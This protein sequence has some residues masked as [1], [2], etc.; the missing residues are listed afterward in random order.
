MRRWWKALRQA[1]AVGIGKTTATEFGWKSA[2]RLPAH[3]A[4]PATRGARRTRRAA[5][6]RARR[7]RRPR[8]S[9]RCMWAP[10]GGGSIRIPGT[11]SGVVGLK[12]TFGRVPQWP[13]GAFGHICCGRAARPLRCV[14]PHSCSPRWRG[15]APRDPFSLPEPKRDFLRGHRGWRAGLAHR[16]AAQPGLRRP[17][18]FGRHAGAGG[19]APRAGRAGGDGARDQP[20][21]TD[22]SEVSP[23]SGA[24]PWPA[25]WICRRRDK[26]A[27]LDAGLLAGGGA[28]PE[29][30][31]AGTGAG[32]GAA[33][34]GGARRWR[35]WRWTQLSAPPC[36]IAPRWPRR[37][38][39]TPWQHSGGTG[40]R[41]PCCSASRA[42]RRFLSPMGVNEAGLPTAVQ[43]SAPVYRDDVVLRVARAVERAVG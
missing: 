18:G 29:R 26:R 10:D 39:T 3:P 36:R 33:R 42:N 22:V 4:S 7:Q 28:G 43:I 30:P 37:R 9:A 32:R 13:L 6:P 1:G 11:W 38:W 40:R 41:G 15:S 21:L 5:R 25:W 8:S 16:P 35:R 19:G 17:G 27:L 23:S 20:E 14:T 31:G 34:G 24:W 12:P 2:G